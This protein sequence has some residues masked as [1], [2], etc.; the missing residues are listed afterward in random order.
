MMQLPQVALALL[1][2]LL[3]VVPALGFRL[4]QHALE[5]SRQGYGIALAN[6]MSLKSAYLTGIGTLNAVAVFRPIALAMVLGLLFVVTAKIS[7]LGNAPRRT[8]APWLCGYATEA[9][10]HRYVAHN[11]YGEIKR[12]FDWLGGNPQLPSMRRLK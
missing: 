1:C 8:A 7:K 12:Y 11:F 6:S 3:G 10:C 2:I 5:A 4:V 9:E